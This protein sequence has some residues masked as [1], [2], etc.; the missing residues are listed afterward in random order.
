[1][2]EKIKTL[3][4]HNTEFALFFK[5]NFF[6]SALLALLFLQYNEEYTFVSLTLAAFG[7]ISSI[8]L[9][10]IV[11]YI[12]LLL[13]KFSD[14]LLFSFGS[15]LFLLLNIGLIVDYF[16]FK[17]YKFHINAMV[18]NILLSPDAM[19]SMQIG[20]APILLFVALI[21]LMLGLEIFLI[22]KL[23]K[24]EKRIKIARNKQ[25]FRVMFLPLFLIILTEKVS[26]GFASLT[27]NSLILASFK[28]IP[29]YQPLTFNRMAAK[30]FDYKPDVELQNTVKLNGQL[31]YP[32]HALEIK[33]ET[34]PFPIII[35]ASDAM[36]YSIVDANTTPNIE[37]F[38]HEALNFENH[39]SGGN[40]TRFGIFSLMYGVNSTYW[41]SFLDNAKGSVLFDVLKQR[42]Y[43]IDIISATNTNWPEFR[44]TCYVN[45]QESI[46]DD[47]E[48]VP[49]EKD[50]Q[51]VTYFTQQIKKHDTTKPLFSFTFLD[52]PHGYS[53]PPEWNKFQASGENIDYLNAT[54]GSQEI[55]S[56][57][58]RYKNAAA[59]DD[60][61]FGE[62][63]QALKAKGIYDD[64]L[65][66]F[67]ADHGQEFYEYGNFGHN[68][69]FSEAQIHTPML[70]KLPKR[71]QSLQV[72]TKKLTSHYDIVPTILS[73]LG[74]TNPSSDYSN[75]FNLFDTNHTR[76]YVFSA[77]W[78][79]NA[80]I[81]NN[82]TYV[83]SNM[84]N[85]MFQNEIRENATYQQR[86][87]IKMQSNTVI[88][89]MNEN[90]KFVK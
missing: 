85:K 21:L 55:E 4:T 80:I 61:L 72:D 58:A 45:V 28:V 42:D 18:L 24:T 27:N 37:A 31:N 73:L 79:N 63:L 88:E 33:T 87:D 86:H 67:T 54:K 46:K 75:G 83:F 74:V 26:Y 89:V 34:K 19:D 10:Y 6:F 68:S 17:L 35:I 16:I 66:I 13:V 84:P 57:M 65:I 70:I 43:D 90:R 22:K 15:L 40:S 23:F 9:L 38:K 20:L 11:L 81:T 52:A 53:Y 48:G 3:F 7:I 56:A 12:V 69:A 77:N 30:Y 64:A 5:A 60:H 78:N 1:M 76:E 47:F 41:F 8:T 36:R 29:L 51:S 32:L 44:K 39:Y 49:W 71:L 14:K 25:L 2:Y 62:M 82:F 59:F 50:K